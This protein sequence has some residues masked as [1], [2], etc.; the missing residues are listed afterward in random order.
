MMRKIRRL[1]NTKRQ[2][3]KKK[4]KRR[5]QKEDMEEERE[6]ALKRGR[7]DESDHKVKPEL[8]NHFYI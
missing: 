8:K 5:R 4:K 2:K 3:E 6:D 7:E 1:L